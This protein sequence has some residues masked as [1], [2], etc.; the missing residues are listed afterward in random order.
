VSYLVGFIRFWYGFLVGDDWRVLA[1]LLL[2][3]GAT[4]ALVDADV[5]A[6][7]VMPLAVALILWSSVRRAVRTAGEHG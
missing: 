4:A 7:W 1:G 5:S 2:G 3:F 6:W